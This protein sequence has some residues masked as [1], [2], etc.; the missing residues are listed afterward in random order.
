VSSTTPIG[1]VVRNALSTARMGTYEVLATAAGRDLEGAL[2]LYAWNAQVSGALLPPLHI[3]EVVVRNAVAD[4]LEALYGARWPWSATFERSLPKTKGPVYS[5]LDDL[6]KTRQRFRTT[7]QV[8]AELKFAF[9]GTLF[10]GRHDTR[11]WDPHL[12]RVLPNLDASKTGRPTAPRD[13]Q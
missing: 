11:I 9:W 8:I 3:C 4:A 12:R 10:T 1:G 7:G 2:A 6:L 5:T 13:K